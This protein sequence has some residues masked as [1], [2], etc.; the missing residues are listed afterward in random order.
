MSK[1]VQIAIGASAIALL[2]G[3][4][5]TTGLESIGTFR[6]FQTL[7][8]F[9]AEGE[10]GMPVRIHGFVAPG[11]IVRD[12]PAKE[13]RFAVQNDPP[14]QAGRSAHV[15][16]VVYAGLETPDLFKDAAEV[17]VE[18]K[19]DGSAGTAIFLA[20]NVLAKCPSKF[21]AKRAEAAPF[22]VPPANDS[23]AEGPGA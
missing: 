9:Q 13:V 15:L 21:E 4:Y 1:G 7:E 2:L 12:V 23:V 19:L 16:S 10:Y 22:E 20:D 17:I 6:Y 5:A 8:E 11:S 18:G 14:H 3:W